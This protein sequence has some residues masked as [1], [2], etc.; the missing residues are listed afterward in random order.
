MGDQVV[1]WVAK[2]VAWQLSGFEFRYLSKLQNGRRASKGVANTLLPSKKIYKIIE[3]MFL[4]R[5]MLFNCRNKVR[6]FR[7]LKF[8]EDRIS[9]FLIDIFLDFIPAQTVLRP[10]SKA[11]LVIKYLR[12]YVFTLKKV[13]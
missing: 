11:K 5:K 13:F 10:V 12:N 2:L 3:T 6:C 4:L 8:T 7:V 1:R 9:T